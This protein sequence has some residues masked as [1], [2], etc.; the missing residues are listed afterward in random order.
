MRK[1]VS[2][3]GA[4]L[5]CAGSAR[6][7][8]MTG[9]LSVKISAVN[10]ACVLTSVR[11]WPSAPTDVLGNRIRQLNLKKEGVHNNEQRL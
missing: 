11:R 8:F 7:S 10:A 5:I 3:A 1:G 2:V 6:L 4:A 9:P